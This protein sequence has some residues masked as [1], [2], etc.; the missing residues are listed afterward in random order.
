MRIQKRQITI[1]KDKLVKQIVLDTKP[2]SPVRARFETILKTRM[3]QAG[4]LTAKYYMG[5]L[6]AIGEILKEPDIPVFEGEP[7]RISR[8]RR[9]PI[10]GVPISPT[11]WNNPNRLLPDYRLPSKRF[12]SSV[13]ATVSVPLESGTTTPEAWQPLSEAY[14]KS[15]K[16]W[17]GLPHSYTMWKKTGQLSAAY[18]IWLERHR[19]RLTLPNNYLGKATII[20]PA[21]KG[22]KITNRPRLA[23]LTFQLKY[24]QLFMT[25]QGGV[26]GMVRNSFVSGKAK[27]LGEKPPM[28]YRKPRVIHL[29][30]GKKIKTEPKSVVDSRGLNRL[31]LAESARPMIARF[32][33]AMGREYMKALRNSLKR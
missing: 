1:N 31:Y 24:P 27:P 12:I 13:P 21:V 10:R 33:A 8:P 6:Q 16:H 5:N 18:Q 2:N 26:S 32:S 17:R 28:V 19:E 3:T 11:L 15:Q 9:L 4:F 22:T 23:T 29:A 25:I 7:K 30:S 20:H 14:A